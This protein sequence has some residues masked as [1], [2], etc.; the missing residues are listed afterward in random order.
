MADG[1]NRVRLSAA[2]LRLAGWRFDG[3]L[4][5]EKRYVCLGYPHTSNWDGLLMIAF[6]TR[7]GLKAR[8]M[9]KDDWTRGP[10]GAALRGLGAVGIDRSTSHSVVAQM[11]EEFGRHEEFVLGIPPE[12]TRSRT[13]HWRSGFY[14]IA[15]GA[16]VP[17]VPG[18]IDF[19]RR[20]VGM[21]PP[22]WMSGD[23]RADMDRLREFYGSL[24][25]RAYE[26]ANVGPIRLR[27]EE[28]APR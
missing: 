24:H 5:R 16:R 9:I 27:E 4:P 10:L 18:Y 25:L 28:T 13:E 19:G 23:V 22:M 7:L 6:A 21:G 11:I 15:L 3:T 1:I 26:P 8:W 12:G 17:V 2:A 20:V 14:H